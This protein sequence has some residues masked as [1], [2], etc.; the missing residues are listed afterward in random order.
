MAVVISDIDLI[1]GLYDFELASLKSVVAKDDD[2]R[3]SGRWSAE[4]CLPGRELQDGEFTDLF[5][6]ADSGAATPEPQQRIPTPPPPPPVQF[7][8]P[9]FTSAPLHSMLE[10]EDSEAPSLPLQLQ[11]I[12]H[13]TR[14]RRLHRR[15]R[16]L[17]FSFDEPFEAEEEFPTSP[18]PACTICTTD[19]WPPSQRANPNCCGAD[20]C[21]D[22]MRQ[23]ITINV[24]EGRPHIHCP[25]PSCSHVLTRE[26]VVKHIADDTTLLNKYERFRLNFEEDGTKKTCPNCCLIT[27]RDLSQIRKPTPEDIQVTCEICDFKWCFRCHAPWHEGVGCSAYKKGDQ[28]FKKWTK[29]R[30]GG[31]VPNC[32]RCP[33]CHV[34]IQRSTGCDMMTCNQCDQVFCY[35]CGQQFRSFPGLGDHYKHL[36]VLGCSYNYSADQPVRRRLLRGGYLGTKLVALTGY[37]VLFVGVCAVVLVGGVVVL[38]IYGCYKLHKYIKAHK[39]RNRRRWRRP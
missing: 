18:P 1:P 37:P 9:R 27:E 33:T 22:C 34:F 13:Q 25:N 32:Q 23:M 17:S 12:P 28:Q 7:W 38:P 15:R 19:V 31:F 21:K 29:G 8:L 14:R 10:I 5:Q 6:C 30:S 36:S 24:N 3:D 16:T 2:E 26:Q 35:K 20:V 4:Y 39:K 11:F